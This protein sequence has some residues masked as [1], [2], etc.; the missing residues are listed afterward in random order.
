[1]L[2][3]LP[4]HK[5]GPHLLCYCRLKLPQCL[6][7]SWGIRQSPPVSFPFFPQRTS[8]FLRENPIQ[9]SAAST[10]TT[11]SSDMQLTG[12]GL[13]ARNDGSTPSR[14][15]RSCLRQPLDV[16]A[17]LAVFSRGCLHDSRWVWPP[18]LTPP[19]WPVG[20]APVRTPPSCCV[21]ASS[22]LASWQLVLLRV[23]GRGAR[24]RPRSRRQT[25]SKNIVYK[26]L[27]AGLYRYAPVLRFFPYDRQ[28][29]CLRPS[30]NVISP[31]CSTLKS[32]LE[33]P[34][35]ERSPCQSL[36]LHGERYR[37]K[38]VHGM[39]KNGVWKFSS[40]FERKYFW[41]FRQLLFHFFESFTS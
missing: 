3:F 34:L 2:I 13:H 14:L 28:P 29:Q 30:L 21:S 11:G 33:T 1:M 31:L 38:S 36:K 20:A 12:G 32:T 9:T 37:D 4:G 41:L 8:L 6:V 23:G 7:T 27:V 26:C 25:D 40:G 35:T 19:R 22:A 39:R 5:M 24:R 15:P 10:L 18:V 16:M 17:L